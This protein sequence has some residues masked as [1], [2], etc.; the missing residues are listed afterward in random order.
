MHRC[1][2]RV[3]VVEVAGNVSEPLFKEQ[4]TDKA[5]ASYVVSVLFKKKN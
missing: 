2:G 5:N 4:V 3:L 1:I